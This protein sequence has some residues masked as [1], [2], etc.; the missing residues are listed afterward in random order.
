MA[1]GRVHPGVAEHDGVVEGPGL[2]ERDRIDD[3]DEVLPLGVPRVAEEVHVGLEALGAE[4][5]EGEFRFRAA[6]SPSA[7][8][9]R[10][11][12]VSVPRQG[13][14]QVSMPCFS[15]YR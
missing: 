8:P 6:D 4:S 13:V 1:R 5:L 10:A 15:R 12:T 11:P 9:S 14:R 7:R 2:G 3:P